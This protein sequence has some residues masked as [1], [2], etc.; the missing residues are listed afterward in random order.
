MILPMPIERVERLDDPRLD[1]YRHVPDPER[2]RRGDV[3]VAEGRLVVRALVGQS[4]LRVRSLLLTENACRG[5][6][7]V[8]EPRLDRL[9]VWLVAE[10]AIEALT[11]FDIHRGC[12]AIGER[13]PRVALR[14]WLDRAPGARRIVVLE[15]VGN[16][17]N[18][19]AIFRNAAA[20]GADAVVLGPRC[21]DPLYRKA[22]RVSMGA[23]LRVPFCHADDWPGDLEVVR[24]AGFTVAALT[25]AASAV[26][27]GAFARGLTA[28]SRVALLAGAEGAG[29]SPEAVAAADSAVRIPMAPL[30]D[31]L[32][33]A[34]ATGIALFACF[35]PSP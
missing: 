1:D 6:A 30:T 4:A 22:I 26:D 23:A 14:D 2:L 25:T 20:F 18:V 19:G 12:L 34:T 11:G 7:D 24:A 21:C 13:P 9:Q 29:L 31:S 35:R 17:D 16:A 32:N 10:A 27:L 15:Q 3:F 28:G 5:L 33:V 8:L